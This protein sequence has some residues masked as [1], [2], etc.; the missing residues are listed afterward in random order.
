MRINPR[1][2]AVMLASALVLIIPGVASGATQ[3]SGTVELSITGPEEGTAL[4]EISRVEASTPLR[5]VVKAPGEDATEEVELA[6][7]TYRI[8]P[9]VMVVDDQRYVAR[10][11]PM[12]VRVRAGKV[13]R[14]SVDY[15]WSNGV[16]NL[17]ATDV[18]ARSVSLD[19]DAEIGEDTTVWRVEGDDPVTQPGRGTEVVLDGSS[20]TDTDL[21]PGTIYSYSIFA[22]GGDGSFGRTDGDPVTITVGTAPEEGTTGKPVFVLNPRTIILEPAD[23]TSAVPTGDGVRLDLQPDFRTPVP[24]AIL[25]L[26]VTE[27]IEGGYLGEVVSV[28]DDGRTVW[29]VAAPMGAAFDLYHLEVPDFTALDASPQA[30]TFASGLQTPDEEARARKSRLGQRQSPQAFSQAQA[31]GAAPTAGT[32][33]ATTGKK[34]ECS[35]DTEIEVSSSISLSHAGHAGVTVDKY[36]VLFVEVPSGVSFD[37][38]Y[39]AT[40]KGAVDIEASNAIEC[41]VPLPNYFKQITLYPVP[42]AL[43]VGPEIG[44][45]VSSAGSM[46]NLG[47]AGT[48]GFEAD[49]HMGF[50]GGNSFHGDIINTSSPTQ[51]TATGTAGFG[52]EVGGSMAFGPGVGTA[53]AGVLLGVGGEFYPVDA[54]VNLKEVNDGTEV[55]T[56][57]E[58]SA[59]T[60][61]GIFATLRA[62]IPGVET[63]I[64]VSIEPLQGTWAWGDSPWHWPDDCTESEIPTDDVVGEGVSVIDDD[65]IGSSDQWGKVEG[66]VPGENTWVLSTGRIQDAVGEPG[67]FASTSMGGAGDAEL[68]TLSGHTTYDAAAFSVT[69]VPNGQTLKVRYAFASEEYPEYV[70]SSFN[71]VMAVFV[72]GQNC[73][74]I[75]GTQTPVSINTVNAGSNAQF[76]VDNTL[77][78]AGYGTTMDGLTTPLTC[79][80]PVTPGEPVA[81]KIVVADATDAIY[82]SAVALLDGGIWSE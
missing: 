32:A 65:L 72:D 62:W 26:P 31:L 12:Q 28:S 63:D 21:A 52:L 53:A 40:L 66:F 80:V 29:L 3:G 77:G 79:S 70:G 33:A 20:L 55:S 24:G 2:G 18:T 17:R 57:I 59:A 75:P 54:S 43:Q 50:T 25:S 49:G 7:G 30:Q 35:V 19:W 10:S 69:V 8:T 42:I 22:R 13:S 73:A 46:S 67:F 9:R 64:T 1:Y 82:D 68:S 74:L 4:I 5:T 45:S 58:L 39:T 6:P 60:R 61:A 51:P 15:V 14:S 56:C 71:D 44:V 16:Q 81:I 76:Y 11:D 37:V 34:V 48:A 23:F 47:F 27:T 41:G 36:K 78:A 38:G